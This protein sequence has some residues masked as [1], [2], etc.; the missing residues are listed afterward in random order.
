MCKSNVDLEEKLLST[1]G[2]N[3]QQRKLHLV[4]EKKRRALA[5]WSHQ[6][7][8]RGDESKKSWWREG[9]ADEMLLH[10]ATLVQLSNPSFS[11]PTRYG[12]VASAQMSV[13]EEGKGW[14]KGVS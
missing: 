13:K 6:P 5:S 10:Q 4:L 11:L 1:S 7:R 2:C 9:F 8:Q 12:R 3:W 14:L